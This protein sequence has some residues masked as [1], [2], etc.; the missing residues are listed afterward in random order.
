VIGNPKAGESFT[1]FY[2]LGPDRVAE[3]YPTEYLPG[4]SGTVIVGITNHEYR[5]MD[6]TLELRL[7]NRPL[8]L[9]ESQRYISLG[10]NETWEEPV[11]F[12]PP[13]EGKD[14]K[15]EFLL[16]NETEKNT[17]YRST[18]LWINVTKGD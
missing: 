15:L 1:E 12:T 5:T 4:S 8:P 3:N 16:F 13:I 10:H 9:P 2:I 17:P 14:M 11:T 6:Y 18:H 7:G